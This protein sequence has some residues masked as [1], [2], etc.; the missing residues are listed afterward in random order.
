MEHDKI[1]GNRCD[2][3]KAE[4]KITIKRPILQCP[5][6]VATKADI[7]HLKELIMDANQTLTEALEATKVATEETLADVR[8]A[9]ATMATLQEQIVALEA[10]LANAGIPQATLDLAQ[11]VRELAEQAAAELPTTPPAPVEPA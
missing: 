5:A 9:K 3:P 6:S 1:R 10:Q 2:Q 11:S 8:T 4:M 7:N